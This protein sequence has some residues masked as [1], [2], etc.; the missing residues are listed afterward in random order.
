M[1]DDKPK[2]LVL[3][4][5]ANGFIAS[6]IVC[7]LLEKGYKVRGTVRGAKNAKKMHHLLTLPHAK[8]N[9]ELFELDMLAS[10]EDDFAKAVAGCDY[11]IHSA[12][13]VVIGKIK[14]S[15]EEQ[16]IIRPAIEGTLKI[17]KGCVKSG[18]VK[19]LVFTTSLVAFSAIFEGESIGISA[20]TPMTIRDTDWTDITK[21]IESPYTRSKTL[22]EKAAWDFIK[23]NNCTFSMASIGPPL[24]FGPTLSAG[25][26]PGH[27]PFTL[28]M[29][30]KTP[31]MANLS[32]WVIDVRDCAEC[33]I[34]AM[35][36][37][38]A[39]GHR[40]LVGAS[41]MSLVELCRIGSRLYGSMG[42]PFPT[43]SLPDFVFRFVGIFDEEIAL[44]AKLIGNKVD[45][46]VQPSISILGI[47]YRSMDD[48]VIGTCDSLVLG[49]SYTF[50]ILS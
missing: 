50:D 17:L 32:Y 35:E 46:D 24:V 27:K 31:A 40:F 1:E 49:V 38:E 23:E 15:E 42:Y 16:R 41:K 7:Y 8:D 45:I 26:V 10:S 48:S 30:G 44:G 25:H 2:S 39:G 19:R 20:T 14:K 18:T 28:A 11:V 13:P 34:K 33:H 43:I 6:W 22:A 5:G 21:K 12:S 4:T 9:L 3:V 29:R 47:K 36:V 37:A